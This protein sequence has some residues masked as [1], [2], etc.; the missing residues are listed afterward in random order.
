MSLVGM[1]VAIAT[2]ARADTAKRHWN[3]DGGAKVQADRRLAPE[4]ARARLSEAGHAGA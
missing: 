4:V 1:T 3:M 2:R